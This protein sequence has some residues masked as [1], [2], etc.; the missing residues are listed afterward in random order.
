[1]TGLESIV[2]EVDQAVAGLPLERREQLVYL[3]TLVLRQGKGAEESLTPE[4]EAAL[5][6]LLGWAL[7]NSFR[8]LRKVGEM[9]KAAIAAQAPTITACLAQIEERGRAA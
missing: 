6:R 1:M 7:R 3:L 2:K 8:G 9:V 5:G 4:L